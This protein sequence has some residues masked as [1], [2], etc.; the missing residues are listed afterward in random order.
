MYAR[1]AAQVSLPRTSEVLEMSGSQTERLT[2][3][4]QAIIDGVREHAHVWAQEASA[5]Q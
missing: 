1:A 2:L 5:H 4:E 3:F